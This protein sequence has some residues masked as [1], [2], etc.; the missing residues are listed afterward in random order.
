MNTIRASHLLKVVLAMSCVGAML[1]V[2]AQEVDVAA[3]EAL[4]KK[5]QLHQVPLSE[6]QKRWAS[7]QGDG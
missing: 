2:Q 7:V 1:S 6:R 4:A 5:E 3:A